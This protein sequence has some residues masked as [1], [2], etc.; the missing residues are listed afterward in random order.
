LWVG[1]SAGCDSSVLLHALHDWTSKHPARLQA[2][3]V[4]HQLHPRSGEWAEFCTQ[5]CAR[6][7]IPIRI[8]EVDARPFDGKSPEAWAR[9][10]RYDACRALLGASDCLLTAHHQDDQAETVLLQLLRGSGVHGLAAMPERAPFGQGWHVRPLLSC[11]RTDL[12]EYAREQG[13]QWLDDPSNTDIGYDRN[14]LRHE[15]MPRLRQRWPAAD[16]VMARAARWQAEAAALMDEVA[17]ADLERA[18]GPRP[19]CLSVTALCD[20]N[21][22]RCAQVLRVWLKSLALPVPH[23][24]HLDQ[25]SRDLLHARSDSQGCVRWPGAEVRCHRDL[26]YAAQHDS[27]SGDD[28][29]TLVD[30]LWDPS[31]PLQLPWGKLSAYKSKGVGLAARWVQQ[32]GLRIRRRQGGEICQPAWRK[33]RQSLKKLLQEADVPPWQREQ[34]PLIYCGEVLAAVAGLWVCHP[35]QAAADEE[36]LIFHWEIKSKIQD[37]PPWLPHR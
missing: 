33:H 11:P 27:D 28:E 32:Y 19:G 25:I 12:I 5:Q 3:H 7:E 31:K 23:A 18:R 10:L 8:I 9:Q 24:A 26:L 16:E 13:L 22:A 2:L 37:L 4:N 17:A 15:I 1:Y 29:A 30:C 35:W 6:Y 14:Y 36:G 34:L 20:L 21:P